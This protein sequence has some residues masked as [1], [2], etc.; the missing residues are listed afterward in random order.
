MV[1]YITNQSLFKMQ[2][3]ATKWRKYTFVWRH[4]SVKVS[5]K[6]TKTKI[7]KKCI[8]QFTCLV[9]KLLF[10]LIDYFTHSKDK[11]I[12]TLAYFKICCE[13][14]PCLILRFVF[15]HFSPQDLCDNLENI[16]SNIHVKIIPHIIIILK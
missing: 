15:K 2:Q 1:Q 6:Q 16:N 9:I 12:I 4:R 8:P 10:K 11:I 5:Q 3:L 7:T 13:H 14:V